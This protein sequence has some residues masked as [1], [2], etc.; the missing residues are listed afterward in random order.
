[1]AIKHPNKP[2]I[3]NHFW[4][5]KYTTDA[6]I[7]QT[8]KFRYSQYMGN[9]RKNIFWPLTHPNPN[10]APCQRNDR[11]TWPHLLSTCERPYLKGLRIAWHNKAIHLITQTLQAYKNT[12]FFTL[13][14][15]GHQNNT[16]PEQTIPE[17]LLNCTCTQ[18]TCQCQAKNHMHNWGLKPNRT[19]HNTLPQSHNTSHSHTATTDSLT[20]PSHTNTINMTH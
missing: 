15:A 12:W 18:I 14:N 20:K 9:H 7:T 8:Q 19:T 13:T 3:S 2:K 11:D 5:N 1:M 6:Q 17:W 16:P 10:C 4:K